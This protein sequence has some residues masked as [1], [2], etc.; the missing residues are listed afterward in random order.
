MHALVIIV[1]NPPKVC[2]HLQN[3]VSYRKSIFTAFLQEPM[4]KIHNFSSAVQGLSLAKAYMCASL[5]TPGVP[6]KLM[7]L[8]RVKHVHKLLQDQGI[9]TDQCHMLQGVGVF[10]GLL[11]IGN[12]ARDAQGYLIGIVEISFVASNVFCTITLIF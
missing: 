3:F 9:K 10:Q 6:V 12:V 5:Y 4:E 2:A 1:S 11:V 8:L 7:G